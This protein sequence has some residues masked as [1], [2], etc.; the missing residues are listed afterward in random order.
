MDFCCALEALA[1]SLFRYVMATS[2]PSLVSRALYTSPM[3]PAPMGARIPGRHVLWKAPL[4][5]AGSPVKLADGEAS[6]LV[7]SPDDKLFAYFSDLPGIEVRSRGS[8]RPSLEQRWQSGS[9]TRI[10]RRSCGASRLPVDMQELDWSRYGTRIVYLGR[11]MN[12]DLALIT[13]LR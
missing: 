7:I 4:D 6:D 13:G 12:V 11:E 2:R 10:K 9:L 8:F 1:E 3:P 5:R